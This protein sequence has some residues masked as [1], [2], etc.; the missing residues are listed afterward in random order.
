MTKEKE[1]I[2]RTILRSV[3]S[4]DVARL[5][6]L[7]VSK[8]GRMDVCPICRHEGHA[9]FVA[10]PKDDY[11]FGGYYCH[12]EHHGGNVIDF[13]MNLDGSTYPEAVNEIIRSFRLTL[14]ELAELEPK[15]QEE[16]S[17]EK[18][19]WNAFL[20]LY[21]L[22]L[23][24]YDKVMRDGLTEHLRTTDRYLDNVIRMIDKLN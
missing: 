19:M 2:K 11:H 14:P 6:G 4:L 22:A 3:S 21:E 24:L 16:V 1:R 20:V 15:E 13:V 9:G 8:Y 12:Y 10:N 18:K 5:R 7:P 17:K 23:S